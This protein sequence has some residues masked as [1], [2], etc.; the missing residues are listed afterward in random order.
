ME[1]DEQYV[2]GVI[3]IIGVKKKTQS[4]LRLDYS[5]NSIIVT[6]IH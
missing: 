4:I 2:D 6:N 3:E 5:A 1:P